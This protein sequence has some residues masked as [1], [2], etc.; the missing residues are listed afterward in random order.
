[1][2]AKLELR[3]TLFSALVCALLFASADA[4]A[5]DAYAW[6]QF[7]GDGLEARAITEEAECPKVAIDGHVTQMALRAGPSEAYPVRL[8]AVAIPHGAKEATLAEHP[9][10]LPAARVDRLLL[11]GDTG[12]RLRSLALQSCNVMADWPF[13]LIADDAAEMRPDMVVH[14][15]DLVYRERECPV[16]NKGCA[17]SPH[18]DNWETWKADFFEPARALLEVAPFVF[19]R[20]NHEDC[21]RNGEGWRRFVSAF[22]FDAAVPCV[23]QEPPFRLDF[24]GLTLAVLDVTRAEDRVVDFELAPFF[25]S[26]FAALV[27]I[28]GPLWIAMHKPVYGSIRVKDGVSEGD[29]KTLVEAA[30][31]VI[32]PNVQAL[33][34]GHLHLFQAMSFQQDVPAQIVA[35]AGGD[36]LDRS[37]PQNLTGLTLGD[38]TVENGRGVTGVFGFAL[39]ERG[40]GDWRLTEF[41][42]HA[43]AL[44]RCSLRGR[45]IACDSG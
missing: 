9:L 37:G 10:P 24:G 1:M 16:A 36:M 40:D 26:Q 19:V 21:A 3:A 29:N 15:G 13:R 32:P 14:L 31:G 25:R 30:R 42:D 43:K 18:G 28:K 22:P 38:A 5:R 12:C 6:T 8:C 35:G 7:V 41:D 27:D 2:I 23:A 44:V 4:R 34:S 39:M 17:G 45:K 11:I 33:L 20:G